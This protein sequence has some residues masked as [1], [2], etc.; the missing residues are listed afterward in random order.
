MSSQQRSTLRVQLD[1]FILTDID[2][3]KVVFIELIVFQ[4]ITTV[5]NLLVFQFRLRTEYIPC[6]VEGLVLSSNG[7]CLSLVFGSQLVDVLVQIGNSLIEF[8]DT[9]ILRSQF[10][11]KGFNLALFFFQLGSQVLDSLF[12]LCRLVVAVL[13]LFFQFGNLFTV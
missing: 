5:Q 13:K 2:F 6:S 4:H 9:D 11:L 10:S 8:G 3:C 7:L 1:F 12:K